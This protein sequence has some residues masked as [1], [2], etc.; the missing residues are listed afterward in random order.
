MA[1]LKPVDQGF[2]K[3]GSNSSFTYAGITQRAFSVGIPNL[4]W[5]KEVQNQACADQRKK[6]KPNFN[7]KSWKNKAHEARSE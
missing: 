2:V 7:K 6:N 4:Y 3:R 5:G 1:S